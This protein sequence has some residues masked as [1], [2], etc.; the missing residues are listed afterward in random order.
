[1]EK[2]RRPK[3]TVIFLRDLD[4]NHAPAL[5]AAC[6][7]AESISG[8]WIAQMAGIATLL[9]V[10]FPMTYGANWLLNRIWPYRVPPE[11]ERQGLDLSE[12]GANAYPELASHLEDLSQR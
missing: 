12:L 2:R 7:G 11:A 4:E 6:F 1:V 8:Q 9:G 10:I 5:C 3:W